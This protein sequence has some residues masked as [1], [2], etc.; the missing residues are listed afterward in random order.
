MLGLSNT[1]GYALLAI[2]YLEGC[3]GRRV[4]AKDIAAATGIAG[5]YLSKILHTLAKAGLIRAKRGYQGGFLLARPAAQTRL[6]EIVDALDERSGTPRCLLGLVECSDERDCPVHRVWKSARLRIEACLERLTLADMAT[7]VC[8][9]T[10]PPAP[11]SNGHR[12]PG[13]NRRSATRRIRPRPERR[14]GPAR[15]SP[16]WN[17]AA[18]PASWKRS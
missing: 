7:A 5:P 14:S 10:V 6:L 2:A 4:L 16:K 1:A 9:H 12:A 8:K 17:G 11:A 13:A 3:A 18:K 15:S